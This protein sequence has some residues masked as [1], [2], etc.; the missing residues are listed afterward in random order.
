MV[1]AGTLMQL[2]NVNAQLCAA[3]GSCDTHERCPVWQEE[4]ECLRNN[5]YM[6]KHCPVSCPKG[7][8]PNLQK[9]CQDAHPNC[10][11]W[12]EAWECDAVKKFCAKSC[13][14]CI[15]AAEVVCKDEHENC[16]FWAER[17][18]CEANTKY[19]HASC[20][21]AC[22]VCP[23][24]PF[25]EARLEEAVAQSKAFGEAQRVSGVEKERIHTFNILVESINYM[26]SN[27]VMELPAKIRDACTNKQDLCSFWAGIGECEKN[28]AFMKVQ[29]APACKSCHM[30][31][32]SQR[33]PKLE[34]AVPALKP[35]DMNKMFERIVA[36]APGNRTL[37]DDERIA[38]QE[39][40]TPEYTVHVLSRPSDEPATEISLKADKELPPWVIMFE[41][42][43][44][45]EESEKLIQWGHELG[46]ELSKDVGEE[47]VDGTVAPKESK[48]RTSENAWCTIKGGCREDEIPARIHQRMGDV[49]GIPPQ[50]SEDLQLLRYELNQ[51]YNTHHDYIEHQRDRQCGPRILTFFLY[52]SDIEEG[53]GTDFPQ[54]GITVQPKRGRAVLW[55]SV[56]DSEPMNKDGRTTHQALP[57]KAGTKFGANGWI[58]MYDYVQA[59]KNGCN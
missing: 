16:D 47:Q 54:L 21:K 10:E 2:Q 7:A 42:F 36:S 31:D 52:L 18:E 45:D 59:A 30:I 34:D 20:P 24:V 13:N 41:N 51:F 17:G 57:V 29:C 12:A 19:M 48:G 25:D 46:Y 33:C 23:K 35:G 40:K 55:P 53:G 43:I 26:Q 28:M 9:E 50:N 56:Y 44:T 37:T 11:K 8:L 58:H 32:I 49:M 14:S 4:G 3:D 5:F 39:S 15:K 6:R 27:Q 38:L 1:A 22:N